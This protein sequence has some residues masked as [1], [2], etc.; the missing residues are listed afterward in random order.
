M[1]TDKTVCLLQPLAN[2][3]DKIA[4]TTLHVLSASKYSI[5]FKRDISLTA[6]AG[7]GK[8]ETTVGGILRIHATWVPREFLRS[9]VLIIHECTKQCITYISPRDLLNHLCARCLASRQPF[10]VLLYLY[11]LS[12]GGRGVTRLSWSN[13]YSEILKSTNDTQYNFEKYKHNFFFHG[14]GGPFV[15]ENPH[16]TIFQDRQALFL[17]DLF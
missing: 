15:P 16:M 7:M 1:I 17:R 8:G 6:P 14:A 10:I 5:T 2:K 13:L 9:M 3:S 12:K 11:P 4:T